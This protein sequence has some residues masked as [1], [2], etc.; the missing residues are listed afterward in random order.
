M[1]YL[2]SL[3]CLVVPAADVFPVLYIGLSC[4][5]C[6]LVFDDVIMHRLHKP[7]S[8]SRFVYLSLSVD[9]PSRSC[10]SPAVYFYRDEETYAGRTSCTNSLLDGGVS[11]N[12]CWQNHER[13]TEANKRQTHQYFDTI[14]VFCC[15][16]MYSTY[17][18]TLPF[19]SKISQAIASVK[20]SV[21]LAFSRN[22]PK[23]L[24][25]IGQ[26]FACL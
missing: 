8:S 25:C 21:D 20:F 23:R 16:S 12:G 19:A 17:A 22:M 2:D 14:E 11:L 24:Q 26:A 7:V 13:Y 4:V 5:A 15:H 9:V 18:F 10:T 1:P 3:S 6:F